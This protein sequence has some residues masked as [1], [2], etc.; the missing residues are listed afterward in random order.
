MGVSLGLIGDLGLV[1]DL[2]GGLGIW[3]VVWIS[4]GWLGFFG[5]QPTAAASVYIR[6]LYTA[7][8]PS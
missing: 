1:G 4:G 6:S 3:E 7:V 5:D 8:A 2:G